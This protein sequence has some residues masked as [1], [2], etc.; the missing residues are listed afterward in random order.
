MKKKIFIFCW[1]LVL[2]I[3][4]ILC[5]I[6]IDTVYNFVFAHNIKNGLVPYLDFNMIITPLC[7]YITAFFLLFYD[8][9]IVINFL[10]IP[11]C[12]LIFYFLCK[13]CN[14]LELP[15]SQS[16]IINGFASLFITFI[17]GFNY[18]LYIIICWELLT[19]LFL[20]LNSLQ[21]ININYIFKISFACSIS[22]LFKQTNGFI[23][24]ISSFV[25]LFVLLYKYNKNKILKYLT[26]FLIFN[27]LL[28][29][30]FLLYLFSSDSFNDFIDQTFLGIGYFSSYFKLIS[31]STIVAYITIISLMFFYLYMK[32][33]DFN[34]II[35]FLFSVI[36]INV[37]YPLANINHFICGIIGFF[38]MIQLLLDKFLNKYILSI[39]F[40]GLFI[41]YIIYPLYI[42]DYVFSKQKYFTGCLIEK[43]VEDNIDILT[44]YIMVNNDKVYY[45][46]TENSSMI[47]L[48]FDIYNKYYDL[49]FN[50]N[51]GSNDG[52]DLIKCIEDQ[53]IIVYTDENDDFW[54]INRDVLNY[55]RNLNVIDNVGNYTIY[56]K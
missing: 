31:I 26:L 15:K 46:I 14:L 44:N 38:I 4:A 27:I 5:P 39:L 49:F 18:N 45:I 28:L 16:L 29:T 30:P 34:L 33:H 19:F 54:Q 2:I 37:V 41:Y 1:G 53:Y 47:N 12:I 7:A 3:A 6:N 8:K 10:L 25:G 48:N 32:K 9:I 40:F 23:F 24:L 56:S 36:Q 21:N 43:E 11:I 52:V 51:I 42:D 17:S 13:I 50:G 22:I 35:L 55:I 20:K